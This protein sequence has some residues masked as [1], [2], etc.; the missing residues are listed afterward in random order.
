MVDLVW[1]DP[2]VRL[3]PLPMPYAIIVEIARETIDSAIEVAGKRSL[4]Q[5]TALA[6]AVDT[7]TIVP[8]DAPATKP[9]VSAILPDGDAVQCIAS[10]R[11]ASGIAFV[12]T[13]SG[14]VHV[15]ESGSAMLSTADRFAGEPLAITSMAVICALNG[16]RYRVALTTS[17]VDG[18]SS[19][20]FVVEFSR[21]PGTPWT[22]FAIG[23][24]Q[25]TSTAAV[26]EDRSD[27][28][29]LIAIRD[30]D[31][32]SLSIIDMSNLDAKARD[33][34][35][36][37]TP[38]PGLID[39]SSTA[40]LAPKVVSSCSPSGHIRFVNS[41]GRSRYPALVT[42]DE[43]GATASSYVVRPSGVTK[44][45]AWVF[46]GP[47]RHCITVGDLAVFACDSG[48]T[49]IDTVTS[50]DVRTACCAN[51]VSSVCALGSTM[52]VVVGRDGTVSRVDL[53]EKQHR[54]S[55]RLP[56]SKVCKLPEP[57]IRLLASPPGSIVALCSASSYV[58]DVDTG[59]CT[60]CF[61][62]ETDNSTQCDAIQGGVVVGTGRNVSVF[63][64][65]PTSDREPALLPSIVPGNYEEGV[66]DKNPLVER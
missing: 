13:R 29:R 48:L 2:E 36:G 20:F 56:V 27:D 59:L 33:S 15:M 55:A 46:S 41:P 18:P 52:L 39:I 12:G 7:I 6:A 53:G 61:W 47:V 10:T 8:D 54:P 44:Q 14:A 31:P 66:A 11:D 50:L 58:I 5:T 43:G 40:T 25:L 37:T 64:T 30:G 19:P 35:N 1:D 17:G 63:P 49:L 22:C 38:A 45:F 28:G 34:E 26:I 42:W 57:C 60:G 3:D 24:S 9:C 65:R 21:T 4:L 32:L 23:S 62:A 16:T 51:P